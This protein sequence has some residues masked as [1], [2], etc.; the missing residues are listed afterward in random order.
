METKM[1]QK[2]SLC[3]VPK[4][5]KPLGFLVFWLKMAPRRGAIFSP[6]SGPKWDQN[7][8]RNEPILGPKRVQKGQKSIGIVVF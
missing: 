2:L 4:Q 8:D 1:K 5:R 6:K 3:G 7:G